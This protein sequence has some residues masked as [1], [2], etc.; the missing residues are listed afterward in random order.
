MKS[1]TPGSPWSSAGQQAV[2]TLEE[3]RWEEPQSSH[4]REASMYSEGGSVELVRSFPGG[5]V[6]SM[7]DGSWKEGT[8]PRQF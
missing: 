7:G 3:R 1:G 6:A 8:N 5:G 4:L 2:W